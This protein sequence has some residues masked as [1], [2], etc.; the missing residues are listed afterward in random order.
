MPL[1]SGFQNTDLEHQ[2]KRYEKGEIFCVGLLAN[3]CIEA[4]ARIGMELGFH[5][6][7]I[8]D[9]TFAHSHE[10]RYAALN[11]DGPTYAHKIRLPKNLWLHS[12]TKLE[13]V[14]DKCGRLRVVTRAIV[15]EIAGGQVVLGETRVGGGK[16]TSRDRACHRSK[17]LRRVRCCVAQ[18][19]TPLTLK[20]Y[21]LS[22]CL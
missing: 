21:S 18:S 6:T 2:L 20:A 7:L 22:R 19:T 13:C 5:V 4:T 1:T 3:T 14:I 12:R 16:D 10:A 15:W 9:A 17:R 8:G 11:I